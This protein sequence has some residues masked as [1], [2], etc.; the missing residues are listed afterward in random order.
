M[1]AVLTLFEKVVVLNR[2]IPDDAYTYALNMNQPGWMADFVTSAL[3][4][5]LETRQ[6]MLETFDPTE[7]LQKISL[8]SGQGTQCFGVGR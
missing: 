7:R 6:E 5:P 2:N 8:I 1:R 4:L 3:L